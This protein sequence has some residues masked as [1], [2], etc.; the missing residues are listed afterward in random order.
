MSFGITAIREFLGE[1]VPLSGPVPADPDD[2]VRKMTRSG[3]SGFHRAAESV[4]LT[5]LAVR[6]GEEAVTAA[7][8]RAEDI[9][10]VV[11]AITDIAEY[12]YWDAAAAVQGRLGATRAE[13]VLLNQGCSSGVLAFDCVAGKF[14]T[15]PGYRTA[16]IV[17]ANR[18]SE[19]YWNRVASNSCLTSDGAVAA[20]LHREQP[21]CRWLVTEVLTDG[22]YADL[23]RLTAGGERAPFGPGVEPASVRWVNP[24]ERLG[25]FFANDARRMLTFTEEIYAN[26]RTVMGRACERA[27][28]PIESVR[29]VIHINDTVESLQ[30]IAEALGVEEKQINIDIGREHG[31]FGTADQLWSLGRYLVSGHVQAGDVVALTSMGNGMHWAVTLLRV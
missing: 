2:G 22:R 16:L 6:A 7:A 3:Y 31:H 18:V 20:V 21:R 27:G 1:A 10:L 13:A 26:L 9:D 24:L 17:T 5:D 11:L 25:E 8:I 30:H 19:T 29:S 28:V 14:A 4:G 23:F 12:L 15:H